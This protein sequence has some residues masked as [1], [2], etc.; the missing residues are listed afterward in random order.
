M[1]TQSKHLNIYKTIQIINFIK[2]N[3]NLEFMATRTKEEK[4]WQARSDAQTMAEYQSI[5][6]DKARLNRAVKEA[7]RQASDLN[8][9]ASLM[10]K[11]GNVRASGGRINRK[12]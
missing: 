12:K 7:K 3:F 5:L 11:I 2:D 1:Q 6:Q 4:D 9:R 8:K 10:G